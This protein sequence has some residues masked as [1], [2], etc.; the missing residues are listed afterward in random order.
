[1]ATI[2]TVL[3]QKVLSCMHRDSKGHLKTRRALMIAATKGRYAKTGCTQPCKA[4]QHQRIPRRTLLRVI[5][6]LPNTVVSD[7]FRSSRSKS[8]GGGAET[9][10]SICSM[11]EQAYALPRRSRLAKYFRRDDVS[12]VKTSGGVPPEGQESTKVGFIT[13]WM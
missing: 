9:Q 5:T 3:K 12:K 11:E 8:P 6:T 13:A 1:M 2:K 10:S 4:V 7:S